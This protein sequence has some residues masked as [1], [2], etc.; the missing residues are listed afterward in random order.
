MKT[1]SHAAAATPR[2]LTSRQPS[3]P[4]HEAFEPTAARRSASQPQ[5]RL[6]AEYT[7][8]NLSAAEI[9]AELVATARTSAPTPA[10]RVVHAIPDAHELAF[11]D[12][13]G[14]NESAVIEMGYRRAGRH[15]A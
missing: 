13:V 7:N 14:H 1:H 3:T 15:H 10:R 9:T 11:H 5:T 8:Q 12:A 2:S 6:L 4:L